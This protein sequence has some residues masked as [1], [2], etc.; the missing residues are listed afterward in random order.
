MIPGHET[1]QPMRHA[2]HM[3][4]APQKDPEE[5]QHRNDPLNEPPED[6]P[7]ELDPNAPVPDPAKN[8]QAH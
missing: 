8:V 4:A 3:P 1:S 7:P 6:V 5:E 2:H